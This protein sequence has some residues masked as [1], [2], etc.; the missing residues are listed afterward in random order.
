MNVIFHVATAIS[1]TIALTDTNKIKTVK[2]T[3]IPACGGLIS[4][5]FAHGIID[6]L[7]HTYPLSAKPDIIISFLLIAAML[8]IANKQYILILSFTIFGCVLPDLVDLLPPMMNK[9]LGFQISVNEKIFPWHM[10]EYSG[11]IFAG[12]SLA[13]DINHIAVLLI[14]VMI[15]WCR[16]SDFSNIFIRGIINQKAL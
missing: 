1:L 5:V 10:P 3:I 14:T 4:G 12:K 9:Y 2:D 8:V 13:S 15:C 11:S 16:R 6:Y 7:P